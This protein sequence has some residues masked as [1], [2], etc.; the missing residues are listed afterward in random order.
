MF[1][2]SMTIGGFDP[3]L[4]AAP[5]PNTSARKITSS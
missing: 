4:K 2:A 3:E 1:P 5:E